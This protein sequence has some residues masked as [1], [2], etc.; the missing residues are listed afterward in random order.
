MK[1]SDIHF[2][3]LVVQWW[4]LRYCLP[5]GG[6]LNR[7]YMWIMDQLCC[8]FLSYFFLGLENLNWRPLREPKLFNRRDTWFKIEYISK[9]KQKKWKFTVVQILA[10]LSNFN[11]SNLNYL[12]LPSKVI[13]S[14][15]FLQ[16]D[17]SSSSCFFSPLLL[18]F[19]F[20]SH[21]GRWNKRAVPIYSHIVTSKWNQMS[22]FP[23]NT[24]THIYHILY[25]TLLHYYTTADCQQKHFDL[26]GGD[27]VSSLDTLIVCCLCVCW[28]VFLCIRSSWHLSCNYR[29]YRN[30]QEILGK[31]RTSIF[32]PA[33]CVPL[34]SRLV[35]SLRIR[36]C[37]NVVSHI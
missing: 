36:L 11:Q 34:T 22:D 7:V 13:Y 28:S 26:S 9:R 4:I 5:G 35:L 27:D 21:T 19:C 8:L 23:S 10:A 25:A 2:F 12:P 30:R 31:V 14:L 24:H 17:A 15:C 32:N 3:R 20:L 16:M 33:V 6:T 18:F 1:H 37:F 29:L